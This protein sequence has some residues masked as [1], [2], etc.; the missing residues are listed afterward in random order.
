MRAAYAHS[1]PAMQIRPNPPNREPVPRGL[2]GD[3]PVGDLKRRG[4]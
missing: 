2:H 4:Q 3:W 1:Q